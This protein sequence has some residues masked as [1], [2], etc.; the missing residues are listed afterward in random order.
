LAYFAIKVSKDSVFWYMA[1]EQSKDQISTLST[2]FGTQTTAA[3]PASH[4]GNF[5]TKFGY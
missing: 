4:Q 1:N 2:T 5:E 3:K